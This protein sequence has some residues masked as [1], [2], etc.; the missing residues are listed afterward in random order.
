MGVEFR[1]EGAQLV[2]VRSPFTGAITYFTD[3]HRKQSRFPSATATA[4]MAQSPTVGDAIAARLSALEE[5]R[6]DCP[7]C[8]GNEALT[9]AEV[10]RVQPAAVR[11]AAATT[12]PWL[13]R[14]FHNL[15]PRIPEVCTGGRNESYVV[16]EDPRHFADE[17]RCEDE[18]LYTALLPREQLR[19]ILRADVAVARLAYDNPAVRAVLIRKN[20]GRESGASQ[21][22]LH[23]QVIGS[24]L[25]FPPV[26]QERLALA[27]A[28]GLWREILAFIEG[29][30]FLLEA[31]GGCF[32]YFCPFGVFPRSYEIVCPEAEGRITD[33]P[34]ALLDTFADLLHEAL[35]IL[36]P[37]ALDYEVHDGVG[38]PLH[39]HVCARYFPYS[40][41]GGTLNLP[42]DLP[43]R[44]RADGRH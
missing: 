44:L 28:P 18:L 35:C 26:E 30:G 34:A 8:P 3:L 17:A 21:P 41:I 7:F 10:L 29:E 5:K 36:G 1:K 20:Q 42:A 15:F 4:A 12:S 23:N 37:L 16:V 32:L 25:P 43:A 38:V 27:R 9:T 31:R 22:H 6:R 11:R 19:A 39:A 14:A 24:D 13:I 40:S 33:M 2:W